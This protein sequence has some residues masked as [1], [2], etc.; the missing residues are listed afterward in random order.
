[1]SY[2]SLPL[3]QEVFREESYG[4]TKHPIWITYSYYADKLDNRMM[5]HD[6]VTGIKLID[7]AQ[8]ELN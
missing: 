7:M 3:K 2:E 8:Y 4:P 6:A 5:L 1:M